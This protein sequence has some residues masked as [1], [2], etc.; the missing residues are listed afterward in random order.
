MN[1]WDV[2]HC[3]ELVDLAVYFYFSSLV[4]L[5]PAGF[6]DSTVEV[7]H[8][9]VRVLRK[10]VDEEMTIFY[11]GFTIIHISQFW[12]AR[13]L[14]RLLLYNYCLNGLI[15]FPFF[16]SSFHHFQIYEVQ[17]HGSVA[18]D[19]LVLFKMDYFDHVCISESLVIFLHIGVN[20]SGKDTRLAYSVD[21]EFFVFTEFPCFCG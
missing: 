15:I 9:L 6:Y 19:E 11:I 3:V 8:I 13:I 1:D 16:S 14:N 2:V 21:F 20:G 18:D 7:N 17:N 12:I 4:I 5:H 10:C